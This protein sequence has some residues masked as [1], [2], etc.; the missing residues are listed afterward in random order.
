MPLFGFSGFVG[1]AIA[2]RFPH[3]CQQGGLALRIWWVAGVSMLLAATAGA[4]PDSLRS[5]K[6]GGRDYVRVRDVVRYYG[7]AGDRL[8]ATAQ[9]R[10]VMLDGVKHWLNEPAIE[11][12]GQVWVAKMDVLKTVDPVLRPSQFRSTPPVKV[13]VLDPGH[14]GADRGTRSATGRNE[15]EF[16]LDVAKRVEARL[17]G[18]G[19]KVYLTR[20][21]DST[22]SL[23]ARTRYAANRRADLFVSIHFNAAVG[24]ASGIETFCLPPAGAASTASRQVRAGD[25]QPRPANRFDAENVWLGHL[26]QKSLVQRTGASDRGVRRARFQVL[27]DATCPAALVECGF[28]SNTAEAKRI[29]TTSYRDALAKAIADAILE[30]KKST[31]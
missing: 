7:V 31:E 21:G 18:R 11:A 1:L 26:I 8:V 27:R 3:A 28:L 6:F 19:A 29:Y 5:S 23:E 4:Q 10:E 30:Y 12:G 14:G 25:G 9:R 20:R 17:A 13:I 15:K 16:T 22:L 24:A 2:E